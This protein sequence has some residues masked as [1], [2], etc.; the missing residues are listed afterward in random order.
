MKQ[1]SRESFGYEEEIAV[2][3]FLHIEKS[4]RKKQIRRKVFWL[5]NTIFYPKNLS[6]REVQN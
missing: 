1:F 6:S 3:F 5:I 4:S 2:I